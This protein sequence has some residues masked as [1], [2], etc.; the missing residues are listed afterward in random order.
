MP[1][2][3][4]C[5]DTFPT[6][7]VIDGKM[8]ILNHR[9]FCLKCSPFGEHNTSKY[10]NKPTDIQRT[11]SFC[12]TT[13]PLSREFFY[14]NNSRK[15][16]LSTVC[17]PCRK[18]QMRDRQIDLKIKCIAYKGGKCNHCG[19]N[20]F[21]GAMEFHHTDPKEKEFEISKHSTY[22]FELLKIELDKCDML[23]ANCHREIHGS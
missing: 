16:E 8:R 6:Q 14:Y 11:C 19:Y 17:I 9:K 13:H 22:S 4:G 21:N 2:C 1:I 18:K 23:C 10:L 20:R 7:T 15:D 5:Q 3:R 12:F